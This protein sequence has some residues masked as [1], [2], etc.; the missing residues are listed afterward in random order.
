MK[1]LSQHDDGKEFV[2]TLQDHSLWKVKIMT[3]KRNRYFSEWWSDQ[4]PLEWSLDPSFFC[5]PKKWSGFYEIVVSKA[6]DSP[7]KEYPY[8]LINTTNN[9]KV[10]ARQISKKALLIPKLGFIQD[11]LSS[12]FRDVAR[13]NYNDPTLG[14]FISLDD[15]TIWKVFPASYNWRN[16]W[17]WLAGETIDQPDD[18]FVFN[19]ENW[20][21]FDEI[22]IYRLVESD[23]YNSQ[24]KSIVSYLI[25]N[26]TKNQYAFAEPLSVI[27]LI[28]NLRLKIQEAKDTGYAL[29]YTEGF[30]K[31]KE[32]AL[33]NSKEPNHSSSYLSTPQRSLNSLDP[34]APKQKKAKAPTFREE[35]PINFD[36]ED[37]I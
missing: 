9:Q 14:S 19:L 3:E 22:Q 16:L 13:I 18:C 36:D 11:Y 15:S 31:G 8:V 2:L 24:S 10:F 7:Y 30:N 33:S 35:D 6:S 20:S 1:V 25:E 12:P 29:G 26:K 4:T 32:F 23:R 28:G 27:E 34:P 17:Q 21:L 5:H 37:P